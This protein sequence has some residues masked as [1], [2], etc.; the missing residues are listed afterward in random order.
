M[1]E[2]IL[3]L[4]WDIWQLTAIISHWQS[5]DIFSVNLECCLFSSNLSLCWC[6]NKDAMNVIDSWK[7]TCSMSSNERKFNTFAKNKLYAQK[8]NFPKARSKKLINW[9]M[10]S[11]LL[12]V[13]FKLSNLL[14]NQWEAIHTFRDISSISFL[15]TKSKI[16]LTL[17]QTL[18]KQI[19]RT[20]QS[21]AAIFKHTCQSI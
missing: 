5:I 12:Q 2:K 13:T 10:H 4:K 18:K 19:M 3:N 11:Y 20:S 6:K 14:A 17:L 7:H 8:V 1:N 16:E 21:A 15:I 9:T